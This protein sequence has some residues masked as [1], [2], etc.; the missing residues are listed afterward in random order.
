LLRLA[1]LIP[2]AALIFLLT[3]MV[4]I[5]ATYNGILTPQFRLQA[6]IV[7]SISAAVWWV[8]RWRK[9]EARWHRTAL[10]LAIL[11]W[12]AAFT[13][14]LLANTE[15]WRRIVMGL[16]FMGVYI[17]VWY[18]LHDALANRLIARDMLVDALLFAGLIVIYLG[19]VQLQ[20]WVRDTLPSIIA[21]EA[22][23]SLPRPVSTLGNP[24][25]LAAVLVILIPLAIGRAVG[26]SDFIPRFV[27]SVYTICALMLLVT[28]YSRAAWI[29]GAAGVLLL[30]LWLL[31]ERNLLSPARWRAWLKMQ[32][33][34]LKFGIA[35]GVITVPVGLIAGTIFFVGSFSVSGRTLDLRTFIYET[36][37]TM[38]AEKPI[39]GYGLFTF[40]GG[41][42]RLNSTPPTEPHSHAH[43][44]PLQVAAELGVVG[45]AALALTLWGICRGVRANLSL[46]EKGGGSVG[47]THMQ[48]FGLPSPLQNRTSKPDDEGARH[49][50][51]LQTT[52][53]KDKFNCLTIISATAAFVSFGIHHL[54]DLPAMNPA[55]M[56]M[57]LVA[58]VV[59]VA[60]VIPRPMTQSKRASE[61]TVG[62]Q[63]VSLPQKGAPQV[64]RPF[65]VVSKDR[66]ATALVV[67][68]FAFLL[69]TG[70]WSSLV[71]FQ[72]VD[73][74]SYGV[75]TG[76]YAGAA[77]RLE[78]VI[79]AD[80]SFA[81][82][83]Q[84][85]GFLL[86]LAAAS[87]DTSVLPDAIAEF[88]RYTALAP[89]Y[90]IGWANLGALYAQ[91]SD[92]QRA[93]AA[94][95]RAVEL[96]PNSASLTERLSEYEAAMETG[97]LLSSAPPITLPISTDKDDEFLP[98]INYVQWMRLTIPRQ[99]L[100]QVGY[101]E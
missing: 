36:A 48:T 86:G 47:A 23:F 38:F 4:T 35:A 101:G 25:T 57:A 16:W 89:E 39:T 93:A 68:G 95:R 6:V 54:L 8:A 41:L 55:V 18:A 33:P 80:P 85:R 20:G 17:G 50:V 34:I 79:A 9:R 71:Y 64:R 40:G 24:N 73:A 21:G 26:I 74:L 43:S 83:H 62:A 67:G 69:A 49:G 2:R 42:A 31:A 1:S 32:Q 65:Q 84:E 56:A 72:Y 60:P 61:K 22:P 28:T 53:A 70:I 13:L 78:P 14:S 87:G 98:N 90:A 76:D 12:I 3:Y 82:Y 96:A 66:M 37:L 88:E 75:G 5:G 94:M 29:G 44:V 63:R 77:A 51:P 92:Y 19:Y 91:A 59:A 99:F 58:L 100:P 81:V 46:L 10:D 97:T 11:V 7:L 45:L 27:M 15:S 30:A 52:S